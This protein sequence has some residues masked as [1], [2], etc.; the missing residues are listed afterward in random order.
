MGFP[1]G[2]P[3]GLPVGFPLGFPVRRATRK[4]IPQR[5]NPRSYRRRN[6]RVK[7][8]PLFAVDWMLVANWIG[9]VDIYSTSVCQKVRRA[10]NR[11]HCLCLLLC[12]RSLWF[13]I[14]SDLRRVA[15][16]HTGRNIRRLKIK[17]HCLLWTT[18]ITT[19]V[20]SIGSGRLTYY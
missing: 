18:T 12:C 7:Q 15:C 17:N 20:D 11:D 8:Q 6:P 10:K 14:G 3:V 1:V 2:F 19:T 13:G 9:S 5:G 4:A 16:H